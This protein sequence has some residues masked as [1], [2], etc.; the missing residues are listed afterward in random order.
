MLALYYCLG[1]GLA[2]FAASWVLLRFISQAPHWRRLSRRTS[3]LHHGGSSGVPRFGGIALAAAFVAAAVG[4]WLDSQGEPRRES[5]TLTLVLASLAM[6][7]VGLTDDVRPLG[8]KKKLMLQML[9][10]SEEHTS[11]LQSPC[12]LVC[13]LL[14]EK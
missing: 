14:L 5:A 7:A 8:A 9:V 6:F 13:R 11:E 10:R 1:F 12:N 2:G 3:Q 4:A